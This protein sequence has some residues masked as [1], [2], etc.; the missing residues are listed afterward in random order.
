VD[1]GCYFGD[2]EGYYAY[3]NVF[4]IQVYENIFGVNAGNELFC[5]PYQY[6]EKFETLTIVG[7]DYKNYL[8]FY[9]CQG[10]LEAFFILETTK[11][12]FRHFQNESSENL[13]EGYIEYDKVQPKFKELEPFTNFTFKANQPISKNRCKVMCSNL[14]NANYLYFSEFGCGKY[15]PK[16]QNTFKSK[17]SG[18]YQILN[19]LMKT[20]LLVL[21]IVVPVVLMCSDYITKYF[22]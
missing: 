9:G 20:I 2:I 5:L 14:L 17:H 11:P 4:L 16:F 10:G 19:W 21:I 3:N 1:S 15:S 6:K 12:K 13:F 8:I 18:Q 22:V 7:T